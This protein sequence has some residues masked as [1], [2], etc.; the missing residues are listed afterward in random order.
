MTTLLD[1]EFILQTLLANSSD[2]VVVKDSELKVIIANN[3]FL[4]LFP[5]KHQS[6]II[7]STL[8]AWLT[9]A[10]NASLVERDRITLETG[11]SRVVEPIT[12]ADGQIRIFDMHRVRFEDSNG[13]LYI[14]GTLYDVTERETLIDQLTRSNEELERF[15]Y[16]ASH[17]LQTPLRM[18][19]SFTELLNRKYGEIMDEKAKEYMDRT[20]KSAN[21]MQNLVADLLS[22]S[23]LGEVAEKN[24]LVDVNEI[25]TY[26]ESN[27]EHEISKNGAQ[28]IRG[29]LP[30]FVGNSVRFS[31]II[32]NLI[33]NALKYQSTDNQP[34]VNI[35]AEDLDDVWLFSVNDNGIGMEQKHREQIFMP[36]KRLHGQSK[37]V[38]TGL[39]L[40]ICRRIVESMGGLIWVESEVGKGSRFSFTIPK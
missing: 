28:I 10:E 9:Q 29:D 20:I 17:D 25:L 31:R 39:G 40:A 30:S 18:I 12:L 38:G 32:Q 14:L 24:E 3:A 37:Y 22:Y 36:F 5:E 21:H 16:I 26:V 6:Q 8:D 23:R 2:P 7:G 11:N 33:S 13:Q 4:N 27:L 34:V 15:A 35:A 1:S 19:S